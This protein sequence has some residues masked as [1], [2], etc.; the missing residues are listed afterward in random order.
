MAITDGV[1]KLTL[2]TWLQEAQSAYQ[3]LMSGS[4]VVTL[5]Y[6]MGDGQKSVTYAPVNSS[7]L[8]NWIG[9]LQSAIAGSGY[10]RTRRSI[11]PTF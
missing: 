9:Q 8:L 7:A 3:K 2:Q 5:T 10:S 4:K 11:H 6:G 1:P